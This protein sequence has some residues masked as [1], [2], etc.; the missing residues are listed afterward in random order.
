LFSIWYHD[1]IYKSTRKDN[2]VQSAALAQKRLQALNLDEE[3]IQT[4]QNLILSTKK[5]HIIL[6]E[7]SDN[8]YLLDMDLSILGTDWDIYK[9]YTNQ[10]RKEYKIYPDFMYKPGRKKVL[11]YFLERDFLYFT[12]AYRTTHEA[13]ARTNIK[14]ELELL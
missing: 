8:A 12:E 1:I 3:Q 9:T 6:S 2:E 10:I 7:T 5:H 14:K 4:I 11:H 13:K